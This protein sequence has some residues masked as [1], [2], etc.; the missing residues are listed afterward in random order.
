M[1]ENQRN[2]I[3]IPSID[4]KDLYL[5][6]NYI[7]TDSTKGYSLLKQNGEINWH[8]FKNTLDYSL[9]LIRLR[10]VY[11]D[12]YSRI[13]K[14][15]PFSFFD[16]N[17]EY[18]VHVINVT[19]LYSVRE[20]NMVT[21]D[22]YVRFGY[23]IQDCDFGDT[24]VAYN[25][26]G[27]LIGIKTN[28]DT[29]P[30]Y[31]IP[32]YFMYIQSEDDPIGHYEA[33]GGIPVLMSRKDLREWVYMNGF[34]CDGIHYIRF[35]RSSGSARVGKCLFINEK[36]YSRMHIY[37]K[38]GLTIRDGQKIDLAA[39]E[40]YIA[41]TSSSIVDTFELDPKS[42]LV[43]DDYNSKFVD[44]VMA[45]KVVNGHLFTEP[46]T[47]E[48]SNSIWDGQSLID[49]SAMGKYA[50]HGMIL[51]RNRFFKS[52][53]FNTNIQEW[54]RDNGITS[55]EQ[56]HGRT[57]AESI[58]DIKLITT[59][60]SIK[61]LKFG[62]LDMWLDKLES[63]FGVV[64]YEKKTHYFGGEMVRSHYQLLNTL[65]LTYEETEQ[66]LKDSL[67]YVF[68]LRDD[69]AVLRDYLKF[70]SYSD[71][72]VMGT[73]DKNDIIYALM[74]LNDR[75]CETKVYADFV[76]RLVKS[77]LDMMKCGRVLIYGNYS[78][79]FGNPVEMLRAT[80][81]QFDG[82][83]Q[84]GEGCIHNSRFEYNRN[85]MLSRSPHVT[86]GNVMVEF[87]AENE[88]IDKYFN[89]TNE[90]CCMNSINENSL[91]RLSGSD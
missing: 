15:A 23:R 45:T 81:G 16:I 88:L 55:I 58:E 72:L 2:A 74:N 24:P 60:S 65:Q 39:W 10:D 73:R 68:A 4:A 36:L 12:T 42:I 11:D 52:C 77:Q 31:E 3:Y 63:T 87:N 49:V 7:T 83:S 91:A 30:E 26:A 40:S 61:F 71:D 62:D 90:I 37:E 38:C 79:L 43:I 70:S 64:K 53:C 44:T 57:R 21:K 34:N 29:V 47:I 54:F 14:D 86:I 85:I 56:L 28:Q 69:P 13:H 27:E 9:D 8:R 80:I 1:P 75:F 66:L 82:E 22:V 32:K 46:E 25:S 89:L 41:L 20:F 5:S 84:I 48:V 17:K 50:K 33:T 59:P 76:N 18:S 6:N 78:T 19:F 35:K 51:V 67:D